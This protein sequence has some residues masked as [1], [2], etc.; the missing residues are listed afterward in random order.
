MFKFENQNDFN[1]IFTLIEK[2]I[3]KREKATSC[4]EINDV[5]IDKND[6]SR[7]RRENERLDIDDREH[8]S[9]CVSTRNNK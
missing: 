4:Q 1:R 3:I 2:Q 6:R 8:K 5:I 9:R 7:V